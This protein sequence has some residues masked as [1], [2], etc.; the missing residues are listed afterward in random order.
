MVRAVDVRCPTCKASAGRECTLHVGGGPQVSYHDERERYARETSP[1]KR[2]TWVAANEA[3]EHLHKL[4]V[5]IRAPG[6]SEHGTSSHADH[7]L[8]QALESI[9][10][11]L[12]TMEASQI[13]PEAAVADVCRACGRRRDDHHVRHPFHGGAA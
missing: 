7:H 6:R 4:V 9:R 13:E 2:A 11:A 12:R 3:H 1:T 5:A 10:H 8:Q